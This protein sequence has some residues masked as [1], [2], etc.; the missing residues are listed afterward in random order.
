M[1]TKDILW[2]EISEFSQ[3]EESP[4]YLLWMVST[5][6]RRKLEE[7]LATLDLTH[8]QFVLLASIGFLTK[9]GKT[10]SQI[11]LAQHANLHA[12]MTSQVIRTLQKKGLITRVHQPGD[13][14][15][16]HAALTAAGA[17]L[18]EKAVPHVEA[19]DTEYFSP[20]SAQEQA[21]YL[22]LMAKLASQKG[23]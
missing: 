18:V 10:V 22:A 17:A 1:K 14:R 21:T 20:L 7:A 6:W 16:K 8:T 13:E 23:V 19:I 4:G 11:E 15:S 12:A 3:A 9:R 2:Q 5:A